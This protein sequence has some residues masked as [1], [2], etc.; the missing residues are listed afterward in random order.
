MGWKAAVDEQSKENAIDTI[1]QKVRDRLINFANLR[2]ARR[3]RGEW[4]V[5][6]DY[7]GR[8][9]S[10]TRAQTIEQIYEAAGPHISFNISDPARNFVADIRQIIREAVEE[11]G[12]SV[13]DIREM[14][15]GR[16]AE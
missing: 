7:R 15:Q 14:V 16:T 3:H 4:E 6:F 11:T 2:V 9:S 8:G 13:R 5:A 1:R 10:L 12:G